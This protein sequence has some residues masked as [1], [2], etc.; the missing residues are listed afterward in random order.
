LN[1]NQPQP[2]TEFDW[3]IYAD[4]TLA[5]LSILIPIPFLDSIFEGFFRKRIPTS[6]A[7]RRG[8][9]LSSPI[10]DALMKEPLT[11]A[12][13][14]QMALV[15]PVKLIW[16]LL[17][18]LSKKL[19]YFLTIKEATDQISLY[20]HQAFLV[21][22]MLLVGHLNSVE[23]AQIARLALIETLGT[24]TTSPLIQLAQQIV[25][26]THHIFRLLRR[27]RKGSEDEALQKPKSE[28]RQQW[29]NFAEY[30][31]AVAHR[32]EEIYARLTEEQRQAELRQQQLQAQQNREQSL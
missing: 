14:L 28:M 9:R 17:K 27:A 5:G 4:A 18:R 31:T 10:L 15:W 16:D 12:G 26:S 22:Y 19:L 20:W 6:V 3:A 11:L 23:A 8:V 30:F 29:G 13:C 24:I 21:D 32:Y 7:R 25:S 1:A 2:R